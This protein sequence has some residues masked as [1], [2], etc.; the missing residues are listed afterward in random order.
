MKVGINGAVRDISDLKVGV[1][2]VVRSVSEAYVGINGAI[3]KVWPTTKIVVAEEIPYKNLGDVSIGQIF[4]VVNPFW[5]WT[6][7][8]FPISFSYL[9]NGPVFA[10]VTTQSTNKFSLV[11]DKIVLNGSSMLRIENN[12]SAERN[13]IGIP[14]ISS[15]EGQGTISC[16]IGFSNSVSGAFD[17]VYEIFVNN[18]GRYPDASLRLAPHESSSRRSIINYYFQSAESAYLIAKRYTVQKG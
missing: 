7:M 15:A 12:T 13:D 5:H 4:E 11:G 9:Q 17:D 1:S 14:I 10:F 6:T 8:G 3:K 16:C 2:G 18:S